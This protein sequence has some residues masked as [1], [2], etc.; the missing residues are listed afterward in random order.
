MVKE[1]SGDQ[2]RIQTN[3]AQAYDAWSEVDR[4]FRHSYRGR[5]SWRGPGRK[6]LYRSI[7][8]VHKSLG[9]RSPETEQLQAD[10]T[11]QRTRLRDR[12]ARLWQ[13]LKSLAPINKAYRLGRVPKVAAAILRELEA[14]GLLGTHL[15]VIG[16]HSLYAYEAAAG[17]HFADA[18]I[19]TTDIDLLWDARR[20]LKLVAIDSEWQGVM[21]ILRRVDPSF[22][23]SRQSFRAANDDGYL[24]D[25]VRPFEPGEMHQQMAGLGPND[26]E[27]AAILGLQWLINA[28]RFS[29]VSIAEDGLPVRIDCVDPRV[30]ALHKLWLADEAPGREPAKSRRDRQQAKATA[31]LARDRLGLRFVAKELS[32]LPLRLVQHAK[33]LA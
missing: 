27:A 9:P 3:A 22:A 30:F 19:A 26:L 12:R 23:R 17:V 25:L 14:E 1:L 20:K 31:D 10:Y 13:T 15:L 6:Y 5:M 24:V 16:T 33:K 7:G 28:P 29:S 4:E 18:L 32:A 2:I 21:G 8:E 11:A